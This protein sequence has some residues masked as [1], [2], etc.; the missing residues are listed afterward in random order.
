MTKML[1]SVLSENINERII[2]DFYDEQQQ[3][4]QQQ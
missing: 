4:Q 2:G 1:L 3:Q